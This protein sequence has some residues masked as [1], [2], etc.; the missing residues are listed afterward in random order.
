MADAVEVATHETE[1]VPVGDL[2]PHPRNY[3][4]HPPEQLEHIS[5]S[6]RDHG[7]Y[8]N[9]VSAR[10]LTIL[11]GHGVWEAAQ[12]IGMETIRVIRLD[13]DPDEPRAIKIMTGDNELGLLADVDDRLLADHLKQLAELGELLGTGYDEQMLANLVYVTRMESEIASMNEAAEWAGMPD[14]DPA[15]PDVLLVLHFEDPDGRDKLVEELK[16]VIAKK[17]KQTWSAP[18]PPRAKKDLASLRFDG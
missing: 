4:T 6:L 15:G 1:L 7:Q 10:D 17:T 8:R 9:I 13:I 12:M 14:F 3:Q 11:A 5:Q 18:W 16:L 2:H